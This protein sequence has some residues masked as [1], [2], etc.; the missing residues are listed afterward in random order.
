VAHKENSASARL[1]MASGK[2]APFHGQ[3]AGCLPPFLLLP[4]GFWATL[5]EHLWGWRQTRSAPRKLRPKLR[6]PYLNVP[7]HHNSRSNSVLVGL[8]PQE[9][10]SLYF[11]ILT[12]GN[13]SKSFP[14][15]KTGTVFAN[16]GLQ[17][18]SWCL[19]NAVLCVPC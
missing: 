16:G 15:L 13:S 11:L 5:G 12:E 17:T 14:F 6:Q 4:W 8:A 3:S 9:L 10:Y 19:Y 18:T 7:R 2:A 1:P